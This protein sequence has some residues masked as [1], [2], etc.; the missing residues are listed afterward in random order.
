MIRHYYTK[1]SLQ[2]VIIIVPSSQK[3][4]QVARKCS[5]FMMTRKTTRSNICSFVS[6][7]YL[8]LINVSNFS[9]NNLNFIT[10][11]VILI[12]D[13]KTDNR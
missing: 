1:F 8:F 12:L 3:I 13:N 7:C 5:S 2:Y 11:N 6:A 4:H 10:I 9:A